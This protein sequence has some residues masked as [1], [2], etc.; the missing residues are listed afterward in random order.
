LWWHGLPPSIRGKVWRLAIGNDL[1]LTK[2]TYLFYEKKACEKLEQLSKYPESATTSSVE[3][4]KLDVSR[5]FPQLCFFQRVINIFKTLFTQNIQLIFEN[6]KDGPL[7]NALHS[8][9]GAY[10]CYNHKIGYVS[11]LFLFVNFHNQNNYYLISIIR[12]K[13]CRFSQLFYS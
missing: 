5:T 7:H 9:L 12:Y 11:G 6:L 1:N 10:A 2:E 8:V 4:I 13:E 3:L